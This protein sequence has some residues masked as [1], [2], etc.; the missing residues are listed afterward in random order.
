MCE[1]SLSKGHIC[2]WYG[3][4]ELAPPPPPP[5]PTPQQNG[6]DSLKTLVI[7]WR[8]IC[9]LLQTQKDRIERGGKNQ[10]FCGLCLH[11]Y[12]RKLSLFLVYSVVVFCLS[13]DCI[14]LCR[15]QESV[16]ANRWTQGFRN[17]WNCEVSKE[18]NLILNAQSIMTVITGQT[19]VKYNINIQVMLLRKNH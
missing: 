6:S 16:V 18:G 15:Q 2:P 17:V 3:L 11:I 7:A 10:T 5:T 13:L 9:I 4:A 12:T 19:P 14:C 8:S 1:G